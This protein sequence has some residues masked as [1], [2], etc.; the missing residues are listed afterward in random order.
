MIKIVQ[1]LEDEDYSEKHF[2]ENLERNKD[3]KRYLKPADYGKI[4]DIVPDCTN[5]FLKARFLEGKKKGEIA[6]F[7]TDTILW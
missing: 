6:S 2:K 5:F 4:V 7:H 1:I 3:A